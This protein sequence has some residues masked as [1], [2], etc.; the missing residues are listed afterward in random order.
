MSP[1]PWLCRKRHFLAGRTSPSSN[2][3]NPNLSLPYLMIKPLVESGIM[4]ELV[5]PNQVMDIG[6]EHE[7]EVTTDTECLNSKLPRKKQSKE[8]RMSLKEERKLKR[9]QEKL[10]KEALKAEAA[11]MK[12]LQKEK[13][14]WEKGK[15]AIKSIVLKIDTKVVEMGL[16]GGS[17]LSKLAEKGLEFHI[18][19]NPIESSILWTMNVPDQI[20]QLSSMGA[21]VPYIL[22]V[23]E[24]EAFC[25]MVTNE[26]VI[27][28]V[29]RV[30]QL[31]PEYIICYCTNK[32][33]SYISK[34]EQVQYKNPSNANSWKR[35]PVEEVLSMLT[36]HF[37]RVHSRQCLDEAEVAEHIVGLTCSLANCQFRKKLTRLSINANGSHIPKGFFDKNLIKKNVWLRALTAIPKVQ[38]R[39][40]VAIWKKYP[41]M[42]CLLNVYMDPCRSVHE[43]E[44]LLKDLMTEDMLGNED[45]RVGEVCS[46]RVY[47]IL[48]AQSGSIKTDD[49]EDGADFF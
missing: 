24:A 25:N 2:A 37:S 33:M 30:Q 27:D 19:S 14:K 5:L 8:E 39:F 18:T 9:E 12:K 3:P 48:M 34:R 28:H 6:L 45:R 22:F 46:K 21:D 7:K 11:K 10:R 26:V 16:I 4:N 17:L 41:T 20:A 31:Y 13:E 1:P 15:L 38:P 36:T 32:L 35:P 43:K 47:R 49:V 44:F 23:H 29:Q 42:R 40:A